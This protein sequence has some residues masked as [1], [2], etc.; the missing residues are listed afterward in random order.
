[1]ADVVKDMNENAYI[2]G[3]TQLRGL[4]LG[5]PGNY[6]DKVV[7]GV[8]PNHYVVL[9]GRPSDGKTSLAANII[10]A[11]GAGYAELAA[12]GLKRCGM[13][14]LDVNIVLSGSI[15]KAR[16]SLL[17]EAIKEKVLPAAP[18]ARLV[19]ARYEPVVGAILLGLEK[20]G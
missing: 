13:C 20:A 3:R 14:D 17:V 7:L 6:L 12:A 4:P 19:N 10:E 9:A 11:L 2:R 1:M 8:R 5:P 16:G 15:F 18:R